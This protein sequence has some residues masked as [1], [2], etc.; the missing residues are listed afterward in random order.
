M[1][2]YLMETLNPYLEASTLDLTRFVLKCR[3]QLFVII[4]HVKSAL[5]LVHCFC[6]HKPSSYSDEQ[7]AKQ[8]WDR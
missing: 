1:F 2:V 6:S 4:T 5:L 3:A 7:T 8:I